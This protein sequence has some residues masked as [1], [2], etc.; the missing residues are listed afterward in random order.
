MEK[1]L[2][3]WGPTK[4]MEQIHSPTAH[5]IVE[6]CDFCTDDTS[7]MLVVCNDAV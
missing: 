5:M 6:T 2:Q 1:P 7:F 4:N 3:K